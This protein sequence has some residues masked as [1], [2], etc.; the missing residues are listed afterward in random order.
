MSEATT[1]LLIEDNRAEADLIEGMCFDTDG[2]PFEVVRAACLSEGLA[3]IGEGGVGLVLLD[4]SLPDNRRLE[5]FSEL[6]GRAGGVPIVVLTCMDDEL[7][8]VEAV[9]A[10]AQDYLVKDQVDGRTLRRC[11]RYALERGQAEAKLSDALAQIEKSHGNVIAD[12]DQFRMPIAMTDG[13]GRIVFLS[14]AGEEYFRVSRDNALGR[15]W[16]RLFRF[17]K[18]EAEELKAMC[19]RPPGE[20]SRVSVRTAAPGSRHYWFEVEVCDDPRDGKRKIFYFYDVTEAR[21]LRSELGKQDRFHDLVGRSDA[22]RRIYR[23]IEEMAKVDWTVLIEGETG[24]G[25]DL[26]ARALHSASPRREKPFI[27]VNCAGLVEPLLAS[28]LFGHRHGAFTGAIEDHQGF[29]EAAAGGTLFLDEIGD[30]PPALQSNLLR[31]IE[32]K[33]IVRLGESKPRRVDVRLIAATNRDLTRMEKEGAFRSDLLYRIRVARISLPP[34]REHR[35]DIPLLV[36]GFLSA[37]CVASGKNVREVSEDAMR[38]IFDYGWPG[39]VRELKSAM[40]YAVIRSRNAA[41]QPSD[42]PPEIVGRR[43]RASGGSR[44][45]LDTLQMVEGNRIRAAQ[46]L[47]ISRATLYR[48]LARMDVG[49][50]KK[51]GVSRRP[52][53]LP[54]R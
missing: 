37:C 32:L 48:R 17:S 24:T 45:I 52:P 46:L 19:A 39:N 15:H 40:E 5:R 21:Q 50:K 38:L 27:A 13:G 31:A 47:G 36:G 41:I 11:M 34:L 30:I 16:E 18:S 10:G 28:Q 4:L 14:H 7:L 43:G 3:R 2:P 1:V 6:K 26:V 35:G 53:A 8:A 22:M 12:L 49:P 29:F 23:Q 44:D 33:E 42:L 9:K 20:R 25:K 54:S 51:S